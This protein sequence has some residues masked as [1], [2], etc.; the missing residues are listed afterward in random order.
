[1]KKLI[2]CLF[3]IASLPVLAQSTSGIR[4]FAVT[5]AGISV[6]ID[7]TAYDGKKK[8]HVIRKSDVVSIRYLEDLGEYWVIVGTRSGDGGMLK[9]RFNATNSENAKKAFEGISSLTLLNKK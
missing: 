4:E 6:R 7:I 1:M 2:I 3:L 8:I 9:Y 5:D